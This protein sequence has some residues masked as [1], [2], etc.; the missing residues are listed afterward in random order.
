MIS[1]T[2]TLQGV[3]LPAAGTW[4]IDPGHADVGFIGRHFGLTKVRGRFTDVSGA[5]CIGEEVSQSTID[6]EIDV[7]SVN[8]GDET[9]D[10]HL[11]SDDLFDVANHPTATFV[12]THIESNGA[13]GRV[14]GDLTIKGIARSVTTTS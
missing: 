9:R 3:E 5:I 4:V 11:R 14:T 6:V 8:S 12:S 7:S 2:R 13:T 10:E 1:G